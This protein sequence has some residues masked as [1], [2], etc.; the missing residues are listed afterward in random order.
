MDAE[1][2]NLILGEW[3]VLLSALGSWLR[4]GGSGW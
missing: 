1:H 3:G 2:I 4:W